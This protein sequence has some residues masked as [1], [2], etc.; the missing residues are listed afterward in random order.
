MSNYLNA[1]AGLRKMY[2]AAIG[3]LVCGALAAFPVVGFLFA[4]GALVFAVLDFVGYYE[5]GKDIKGCQVAFI[6]RIVAI[7]MNV[8][9]G[10]V[11]AFGGT[12]LNVVYSLGNTLLAVLPVCL[13]FTSVSKVQ[14]ENGIQDMAK[15]GIR[16]MWIYLAC[17]VLIGIGEIVSLISFLNMS[18]GM[19]LLTMLIVLAFSIVALVVQLKYYKQSAEYFGVY[20]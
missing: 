9:S 6:L 17:Y 12:S 5:A 1:G 14:R 2:V 11:E 16:A 4:I 13:V 18:I 19:I 10:I 7:V 8:F 20:F 15:K 3:V